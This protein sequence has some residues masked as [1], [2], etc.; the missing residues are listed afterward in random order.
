[1]QYL[2]ILVF[3]TFAACNNSSIQPKQT[4]DDISIARWEMYKWL[5]YIVEKRYFNDE[6]RDLFLVQ[7]CS[8]QMS[9]PVPREIKLYYMRVSLDYISKESTNTGI[10][11][12]FE[13][14]LDGDCVVSRLLEVPESV[15]ILNSGKSLGMRSGFIFNIEY[16][17]DTFFVSYLQTHKNTLHP[18]LRQE[19]QRRGIIK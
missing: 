3:F 10:I 14:N 19:A 15:I 9:Q 18:W 5:N 17:N 11:Y 16:P 8:N 2:L 6:R 4:I 12:Y 1:M 7:G 13:M